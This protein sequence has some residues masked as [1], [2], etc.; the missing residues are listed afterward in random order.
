MASCSS[1]SRRGRRD[2]TVWSSG[3]PGAQVLVAED[4]TTTAVRAAVADH[5]TTDEGIPGRLCNDADEEV[6][7]PATRPDGFTPLLCTTAP[8]CANGPPLTHASSLDILDAVD[9]AGRPTTSRP[10]QTQIPR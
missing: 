7:L 2:R 1:R 4:P 10:S 5:P 3:D 8:S 9:R 6:R